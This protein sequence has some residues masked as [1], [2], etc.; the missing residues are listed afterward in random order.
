M[1]GVFMKKHYKKG[2]NKIIIT[3]S[4]AFLILLSA[5]LSITNL[6]IHRNFIYNDYQNYIKDILNYSLTH[7]D[8]D[9]LKVCIETK[10]ESVKYKETLKFM[11]NIMDNFHDIHY[12][13][14]IV[15]L[16]K[17]KTGNVM[18]VLSAE[19][20]QDRYIDTE[21]N[22]YLGWISD[23]EFDVNTVNT[24]FQI[25][26]SKEVVFFEERTGWGTD[27]TGAIPI[28]DSSG[29]SIAILAVDIDI[30]FINGAILQYSIVNISIITILGV[31][32]IAI[33]FLWSRKNIIQPIQMLEQR[34]G[35]FVD[36]SGG[37]RDVEA[38]RFDPPKIT[39]DNE[40]KALSDA[41]VKMT[42]DMQDYVIDIISAE[43]KAANMQELANVDA[44]TGVRNKLA[45]DSAIHSITDTKVGIVVIDLN[46]LKKINDTYGHDKG[47][48]II[49][50]LAKV[51]CEVFK[52]SYVYRIG[53]DEFAVILRR[54]DYYRYN[55]LYEKINNIFEE[56]KNNDSLE[57]WEKVSAAVGAA[58]FEEG[59]DME[60]L[61][62]RADQ[63][64]YKRKKE[65]KGI[66][67]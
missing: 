21:G 61:F 5:I 67:E 34:A 24:Y 45:Y 36:H 12:F 49:K 22:L 43:E 4:I 8:S 51:I 20:Y 58:F 38:L 63:A 6:M 65:M 7:I 2:L 16:N 31:A 35:V 29:N 32:F 59:D 19:R 14:S 52:H 55:T 27:Y 26:E 56:M 57:P 60:S 41:V 39:A 28:R 25:M 18:S 9:D 48:I 40:I 66:K 1:G 3:G 15:P 54:Y 47:D 53:G 17:E 50:N 33:F 62:N 44:L 13:Y 37:Q 30:S 46:N 10:E 11:D 23:D 42:K 64:M